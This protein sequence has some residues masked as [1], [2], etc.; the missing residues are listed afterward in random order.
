M[1][2]DKSR[3][4]QS[5]PPLLSRVELGTDQQGS[6]LKLRKETLEKKH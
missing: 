2:G 4:L 5:T 3:D 6:S 1:H